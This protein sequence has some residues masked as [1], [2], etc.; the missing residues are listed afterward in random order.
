MHK[1]MKKVCVLPHQSTPTLHRASVVEQ[2]AEVLGRESPT[3]GGILSTSS[4]YDGERMF[5]PTNS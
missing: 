2:M 4:L 1:T 3:V 5:S